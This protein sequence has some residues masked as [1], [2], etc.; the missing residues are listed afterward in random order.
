MGKAVDAFVVYWREQA[1]LLGDLFVGTHLWAWSWTP[2]GY[3]AAVSVDSLVMFSPQ[4][5]TDAVQPHLERISAALGGLVTHSCGNFSGVIPALVKTSGLK[6]VNASQMSLKELVDAGLPADKVAVVNIAFDKLVET[7]ALIS[8]RGQRAELTFNGVWP[9]G[10]PGSWTV[11]KWDV[12]HKKVAAIDDA[13]H[14]T[15]KKVLRSCAV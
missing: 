12:I 5:Y 11:E 6:G 9:E 3:G 7:A 13:M 8:A 2:P 1:L 10:H 4:F 15:A 14:D